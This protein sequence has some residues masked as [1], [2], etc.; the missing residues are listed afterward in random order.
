[1]P[2]VADGRPTS[3]LVVDDDED[4][5]ALVVLHLQMSGLSVREEATV[6][7]GL[8]SLAESAPDIVLTD[9]NFGS[10]TGERIIRRCRELDQPVI[11]MTASAEIR[12]I[13]EDLREGLLILRKPFALDDLSAIVDEALLPGRSS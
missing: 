9:L 10:D 2:T 6:D 5:R 11:L 13:D 7:S 4:V 8:A 3:I 1:V 12:D